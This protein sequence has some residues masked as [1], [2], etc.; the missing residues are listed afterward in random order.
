MLPMNT[1]CILQNSLWNLVLLLLVSCSDTDLKEI[2]TGDSYGR[3]N[4]IAEIGAQPVMFNLKY[5]VPDGYRVSFEVYGENPLETQGGLL[6]KK[7]N[8][9]PIFTGITNG[10]GEYMLSRLLPE[11]AGDL[12]VYSSYIGVPSLLYGRIANGTADFKEV[13]QSRDDAETKALLGWSDNFPYLKLGGWNSLGKP[14]YITK[15]EDV[16]SSIL[17]AINQAFPEWKSAAPEYRKRT[18]IYVQKDAQIWVSMLHSGSLF[19]N[20]LGYFS[21]KGDIKDVDPASIKEIIAFPRASIVR[22][23]SSGLKAG[24]AVQLKY[25]NPETGQLENTFPQGTSIGWVLRSDGYNLLNRTISDGKFRFY[26]YPEWNPESGNKSHTVLFKKDNFVVVGFEDLPNERINL[27]KG[28]GDCNDLMFHVS[29]Y[30]ADAI[31]YDIPE[32]PDGSGATEETEDVD[33]IQQLSEVMDLPSDDPDFWNDLWIASKSTLNWNVS[34]QE[35][36]DSYGSIVGLKEEL[37]VANSRTMNSLI[38]EQPVNAASSRIF[39]KT[40]IRRTKTATT[41]KKRI[42]VKTTVRGM[43]VEVEMEVDAY[44]MSIRKNT[45]NEEILR[46]ILSLRNKI[47]ANEPIRI[48]VEMEFDPIPWEQFEDLVPGPYSPHIV[49]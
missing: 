48:T 43:T 15:K 34:D 32:I 8:L 12:Y 33:A 45:A 25:Y 41:E 40:T 35:N 24:E 36:L 39:V 38:V 44:A 7:S 37:I 31:T 3:Q 9:S 47:D 16:S 28:D 27:L 21:Y 4:A 1:K 11:Q 23:L 10:R 46:K 30:P 14:D 29:S 17:K 18:D 26:S 6:V 42:F 2:G 20:V 13:E 19:D 49:E 22:L 5:D